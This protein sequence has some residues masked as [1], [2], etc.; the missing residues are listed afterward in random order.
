MICPRAHAECKQSNIKNMSYTSTYD[1]YKAYGV[2]MP[3]PPSHCPCNAWGG[4]KTTSNNEH[5]DTNNDLKM[6][7]L[8]WLVE[9]KRECT[10]RDLYIPCPISPELLFYRREGS[11]CNCTK[12]IWH[13]WCLSVHVCL[14]ISPSIHLSIL[15]FI[16]P[17]NTTSLHFPTPHSVVVKQIVATTHQFFSIQYR[18]WTLSLRWPTG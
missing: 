8:F 18:C 15:L 6:S 9:K 10:T 4:I 5:N 2:S 14:P 13:C 1:V 16:H 12:V 11:N 3:P 17:K 7:L